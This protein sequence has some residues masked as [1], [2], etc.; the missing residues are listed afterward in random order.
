MYRDTI[1]KTISAAA[2]AIMAGAIGIAAAASASSA[3]LGTWVLNVSQSA[4]AALTSEAMTITQAASGG[5]H[6]IIERTGT[7]GAKD[8]M[9]YTTAEDGKTVPVTGN[10]VVTAV[11][12]KVIGNS[13][14]YSFWSKG[15]RLRWGA[16]TISADGKR[17]AGYASTALADGKRVKSTL[18]FD[19]R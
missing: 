8:R 12:V 17:L 4:N 9:E 1:L 2:F 11:R 13:A 18:V 15:K 16:L 10:P 3:F 19:R 7:D 5:L 6:V 14:T